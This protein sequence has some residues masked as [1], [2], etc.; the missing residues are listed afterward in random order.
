MRALV[1]VDFSN[2]MVEAYNKFLKYRFLYL[3]DFPDFK[4]LERYLPAAIQEYNEVR[5]HSAHGVLT[6]K[7]V[8]DGIQ[9]SE[10][11]LSNQIKEARIR[12]VMKHRNTGCMV[13]G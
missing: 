7:E 5:P 3:K 10:D 6:P 9:L 8:L 4:A 12:R 1:D 13:C 11:K 2:S